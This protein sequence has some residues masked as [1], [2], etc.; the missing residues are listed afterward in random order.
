MTISQMIESQNYKNIILLSGDENYLIA[1]WTAKLVDSLLVD[2]DKTMNFEKYHQI[3]RDIEAFFYSL[4][5]SPFLGKYRIILLQ[6]VGLFEAKGKKMAERLAEELTDLPQ[7]TILICQ[8]KK[9]DKRSK[10]HKRCQKLGEVVNYDYLSEKELTGFIAKR[11]GRQ[12]VKIRRQTATYLIE[13]AGY[14]LT[15]LAQECD[16]LVAYALMDKV[17]TELMIDQLVVAQIDAKIFDLVDAVGLKQQ[18][19]A[20]LNYDDLLKAREPES[21]I[22]FMLSRQ[23]KLLLN[24]KLYH[25]KKLPDALIVKKIGV[26]NF[27]YRKL[28][29]QNEYFSQKQLQI[30][31]KDC[32]Q[33][34]YE[35]K[36]G[37]I[38]LRMGLELLIIK[39][40]RLPKGK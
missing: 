34:E 3:P 1:Y 7:S 14:D 38:D 5:T 15:T 4:Q 37:E 20:L 23:I 31:L 22:L 10:F 11:L 30:A 17:V 9:V 39:L 35:F 32:V 27:V 33:L 19:I 6:E 12:S 24:N 2:T 29:R 26:P 18:K 21:R 36:R 40:C 16:K 28:Q 25:K 13:K 8:E